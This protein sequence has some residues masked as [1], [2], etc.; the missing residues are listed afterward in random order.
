VTLPDP[1][2]LK[3][4]LQTPPPWPNNVE[5]AADRDATLGLPG[6]S[7]T[8]F[9]EHARLFIYVDGQPVLVPA[10]IGLSALV[11]SP[12]HTHE[13]SGTIHIESDDLNF[14]AVLGQFMDVW[15][16]YFTPTCI[17]SLCNDGDKQL[18][19]FVNGQP[20]TGDPTLLQLHEQDRVV[21]TYGTPD[22]VPDPLPNDAP[23]A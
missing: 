11:A 12:L 4:I 15:G 6:L 3:G 23:I 8:V 5:Q 10:N 9:H 7:D 19:V 16:V 20:Y 17:G 13:E 22:Q 18:R 21:V 14:Q 2:T 1:A